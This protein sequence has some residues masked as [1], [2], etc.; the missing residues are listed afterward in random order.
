M[1][2]GGK[3]N[4]TCRAVCISEQEVGRFTLLR[5]ILELIHMHVYNMLI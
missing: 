2:G 5:L 3:R 4:T 1:R